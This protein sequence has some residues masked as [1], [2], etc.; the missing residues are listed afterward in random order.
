MGKVILETVV[1]STVYGTAVQDGLEDLDLMAVVI[2]DAENFIGFGSEDVSVSRTKPEGVRSEAGDTD[3]VEYGLRKFL[4]LALKGNPSILVPLFAPPEFTRIET[5][6]GKQLKSLA[7]R[8]I[9]RQ[10]HDPF[11]GYMIQQRERLLGKRNRNVTRP[12]LVEAYG[13]DT[14]FAGHAVRL[15]I[16][17]CEILRTGRLQLPMT[18]RDRQWVINVRNGVYTIDEVVEF[19]STLELHLEKLFTN[20]TLQDKPDR[21]FV[22]RWMVNA[23]LS[24]WWV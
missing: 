1:G 9:S 23:Y 18:V 12:E 15:G 14:K 6:E 2:E 7:S 20:S 3:R 5:D 10:V 11:R 21:E 17:G 19:I 4:S 13:Y 16:Q 22:E 24:H 8:I